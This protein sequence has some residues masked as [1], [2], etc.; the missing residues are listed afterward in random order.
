MTFANNKLP[1][2]WTLKLTA[3]FLAVVLW[4]AVRGNPGEDR[5]VPIPLEF[6]NIPRGMEITNEPEK[7]VLATVHG[8]VSDLGAGQ[9]MLSCVIDLTEMK[10]GEQMIPISPLNVQVP[11]T[12][13][14]EIDSV[15]PDR[16][17]IVLEQTVSK[18]VP[19]EVK[20]GK[21]PDGYEVY[22]FATNPVSILIRGPS[23]LV[24]DRVGVETELIVLDGQR[25][26]LRTVVNLSIGDQRIRSPLGTTPIEVMVEI[27]LERKLQ[28]IRKVS[29]VSEDP[30]VSI[31]PSTVTL[32][33]LA[34]PDLPEPLEAEDFSVTVTSRTLDPSLKN[35]KVKPFI[36]FAKPLDPSIRIQGVVPEEVT[37]RRKTR[38]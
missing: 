32:R 25:D 38:S 9:P 29:V 12:A 3:L 34:P 28:T 22:S 5:I 26:S 23:S 19:I 35:Q 36:S 6:R 1:K 37:V 2:N 7:L 20:L 18:V 13:G 24:E 14:L 16:I 10:E 31:R 15:R 30:T 4:L 21:P 8:S 33:V 27:G 17:S 11:A